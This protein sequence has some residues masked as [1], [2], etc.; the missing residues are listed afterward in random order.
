MKDLGAKDHLFT[1]SDNRKGNK[2]VY[3]WL[4]KV[5]INPTWATHIPNTMCIN[6]LVI[7]S[8][9]AP[10]VLLTQGE[11]HRWKREFR[12]EEM[13]MENPKCKEVI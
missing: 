12:F 7:G 10:L 13:W 6:E 2:R 9:H 8:D 3:E 4:D 5:L 1:R 11:K